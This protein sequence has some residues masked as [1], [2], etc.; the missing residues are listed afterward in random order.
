MARSNKCNYADTEQNQLASRPD[1]GLKF[2]ALS[3]Q[4]SAKCLADV[5]LTRSYPE[6]P[7][8]FDPLLLF[9][10]FEFQFVQHYFR[11][12]FAESRIFGKMWPAI[13]VPT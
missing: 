8:L 11:E 2:F 12:T 9:F 3:A 5:L 1:R 6:Y 4:T 10:W 7:R 13:D